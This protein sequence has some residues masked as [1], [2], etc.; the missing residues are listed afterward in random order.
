MVIYFSG[1]RL[2]REPR[3]RRDRDVNVFILS[4]N[5]AEG[6]NRCVDLGPSVATC[7]MSDRLTGKTFRESTLGGRTDFRE[8]GD[9]IQPK[10]YH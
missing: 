5:R 2:R 3:D 4:E 7:A 9:T 1:C 6:R 8:L 10:W